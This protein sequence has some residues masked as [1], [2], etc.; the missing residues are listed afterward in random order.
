MSPRVEMLSVLV[1]DD[2]HF[3][4][5]VMRLML[6]GLGIRNVVTAEDVT[7]ALR[8]MAINPVDIVIVDYRLGGQTGAEFTRLAR[9]S[10]SGSDRF[11]PIIACT[12]DTT[13]KTIQELRDAGA[14]EILG[15]PV[16]PQ[17]I[18]A[19]IVAVT[20]SRRQFVTT[21]D[22]FGPDRR[23]RSIPVMIDRRVPVNADDL[24][25]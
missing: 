17:T 16:S 10:R 13:P 21:P 12:A 19:K 1:L 4:R 8:I 25:I 2:H 6:N 23:R 15:K 11:V 5:Q 20:N 18:W 9:T 7:G 14:D 24:I 3:M 22:F